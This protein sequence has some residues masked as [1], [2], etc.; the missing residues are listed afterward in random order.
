MARRYPLPLLDA[1][2]MTLFTVA[3]HAAMAQ[4]VAKPDGQWRGSLGAG[5]TAT[6]GNTDSITATLNGD[7]VKQTDIDKLSGYVQAVYG[8]RDTNGTTERTSDLL[9]GGVAYNHDT[10]ERTFGFGSLDLERN[11]L[12]DL[13]LRSVAATGVGYHVIKRDELTFDVSTGPAYNRE[14]YSDE[15][16]DAI[17]WLFAQESTHKLNEAVSFRQRLALYPNLRDTGE[18]RFV[19]DAGLVIK[20]AGNWNATISLNDRYQSNP[21]PGV[22]K[23]DLLFVTGLQYTFN[24]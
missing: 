14:Q 21:L 4:T 15:T 22:K 20:M 9:R 16:R 7:A 1:F 10:N 17:E 8:R 18:Y 2:V 24:P 13:E 6:S 23:N 5:F 12:I 11:M 3:S 19:F